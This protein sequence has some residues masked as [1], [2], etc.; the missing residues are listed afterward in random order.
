[1][2]GTLRCAI[3]LTAG[4]LSDT[5]RFLEDIRPAVTRPGLAGSAVWRKR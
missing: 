2:Q 5:G 4:Y 3:R 1:M